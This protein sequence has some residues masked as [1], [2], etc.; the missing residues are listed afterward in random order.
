MY[1]RTDR[2]GNGSTMNDTIQM[3]GW[4]HP[5]TTAPSPL[6][7]HGADFL[8]MLMASEMCPVHSFSFSCSKETNKA[9]VHTHVHTH[10]HAR[11]DQFTVV[12]GSR[13][14]SFAE[15]GSS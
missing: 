4:A 6:E 5:P 3:D 11:T 10:V 2:Q 7:T 12:L 15:V 8:E 14:D 1:R 13:E 9:R